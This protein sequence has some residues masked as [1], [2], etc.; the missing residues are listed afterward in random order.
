M[1]KQFSVMKRF[2]DVLLTLVVALI[3]HT[4]SEKFPKLK[5]TPPRQ[6]SEV[7]NDV[8]FQCIYYPKDTGNINDL[9]WFLPEGISV[10]NIVLN[11][12]NMSYNIYEKFSVEHGK[13]TIRNISEEDSGVYTCRNKDGSLSH[14]ARLKVFLMPSYFQEGMVVI[15]INGSLIVILFSCFVWTT[16]LSR[17]E[18]KKISRHEKEIV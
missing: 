13:L 1:S 7:G 11:Q 12:S 2:A 4:S 10:A 18:F 16:Y 9:D 3:C 15:T 5:V 8:I 14:D 6:A 17:K